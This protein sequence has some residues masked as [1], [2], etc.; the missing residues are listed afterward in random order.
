[1]AM[2]MARE[3]VSVR[4]TT[5]S[6]GRMAHASNSFGERVDVV[7]LDPLAVHAVPS[8]FRPLRYKVRL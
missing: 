6:A 7:A 2:S 4:I 1:M 8:V 3:P 5:C